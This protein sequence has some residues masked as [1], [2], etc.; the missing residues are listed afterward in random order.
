M[1]ID[2][3]YCATDD[4]LYVYLPVRFYEL[5]LKHRLLEQL[6]GFSHL[7]LDALT[8][9][10]EQGIDWVLELTG[11]SLQQLQPILN[12]LD[13]L[14]LVNGGQLSQRGEKLTAWKGLLHGQ[15]RHVW[16]DGHHKSHSFCGDDSLNVVELGEDA[17]FVIRRWHQGNGKPRSWSCLDWNEDCERQKNRILRS[18]DE[19]LGVVFETFRNCFIGT[20]FN[21]H[22]WELNVRY[23]SGMPEL[24]ALEVQ[25]DPACLGSGAAYDF[26][27][28]SP[29]LCMDTRYRLPDGAPI[30]L[31][32]LQ[33]EDQRRA[34]SFGRAAEDTGLL[35]DTP[36]SFWIWPE[37]DEPDRQQAVNFLFQNVAVS[38]SQNEALFNRDHHLV[39]LWQSVGFDWSAVEGS[40]QEVEGLHRIKGDT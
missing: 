20:G 38:A 13:G 17:S 19:Y 7:L 37:V 40:L 1:K 2:N 28:S 4:G 16:L 25:L 31:R 35:L 39:D 5:T 15:T 23:V 21:V 18:P 30:E 22:E 26:V 9:L 14:G 12:R 3:Y 6:G 10:P 11:L 29:V 8:L 36:D 33:P 34:L 24:S 32:D 27:V